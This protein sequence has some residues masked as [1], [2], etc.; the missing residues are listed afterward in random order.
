M[1][2]IGIL[3]ILALAGAIWFIFDSMRAREIATELAR[4]YCEKRGVQFLDGSAALRSIRLVRRSN[5]MQVQR[6]FQF[7]HTAIGESRNRGVIIVTGRT[8]DHFLLE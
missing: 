4:S 6:R 1:D 7:E 2:F 8:V 3:F 5:F